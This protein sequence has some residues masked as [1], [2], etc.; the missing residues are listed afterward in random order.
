ML[1]VDESLDAAV[2]VGGLRMIGPML[3]PLELLRL[4]GTRVIDRIGVDDNE[5][6]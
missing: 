3:D 1:T 6:F 4:A 2:G 5:L